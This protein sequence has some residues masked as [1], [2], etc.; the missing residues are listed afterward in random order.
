MDDIQH[1]SIIITRNFNEVMSNY[2]SK[3]IIKKFIS[4]NAPE[5]LLQQM[6]WKEIYVVED[7]G[8]IID[9]GAL[10]RQKRSW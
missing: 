7:N 1:I 4:H 3:D 2:H 10:L 8:E 6:Q 5:L 9:T